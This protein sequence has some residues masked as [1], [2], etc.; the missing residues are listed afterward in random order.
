ME[1][2][3]RARRIPMNTRLNYLLLLSALMA[4]TAI[5]QR[6]DLVTVFYD[7][8]AREFLCWFDGPPPTHIPLDP[9]HIPGIASHPVTD[10]VYFFRGQTVRV[11]LNGAMI[12][13]LFSLG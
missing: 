2:A 10:G 6:A 3:P 4:G 8:P 9:C 13:D 5:A 12:A 11:L 7:A 1:E